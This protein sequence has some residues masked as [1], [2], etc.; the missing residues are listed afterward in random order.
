ME[1][2][3]KRLNNIM[4]Q[5]SM[6]SI[7]SQKKLTLEK[8]LENYTKGSLLINEATQ[9][10][11]KMQD[12]IKNLDTSKIDKLNMVKIN[13]FIKLLTTSNPNFDEVLFIVE[14]LRALSSD[15]PKITEITDNVD[16]EIIYADHN[17]N[18][19]IKQI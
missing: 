1:T 17:I 12:D 15:L 9:L 19:N 7:E 2:S 14:Q 5:I 10:I 18:I 16:R 8:K 11:E 13:E 3:S 6:I 4:A